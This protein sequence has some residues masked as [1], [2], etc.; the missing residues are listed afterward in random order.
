MNVENVGALQFSNQ[1]LNYSANVVLASLML[2][3]QLA[4]DTPEIQVLKEQ[5]R[6]N[7]LILQLVP[8]IK[9]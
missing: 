4:V 5:N 7:I 6:E 1:I 9:E 2:R 3:Q 8:H